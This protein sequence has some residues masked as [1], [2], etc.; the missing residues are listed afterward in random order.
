[1]CKSITSTNYQQH[2]S[3]NFYRC[4]IELTTSPAY[5]KV[6]IGTGTV[7]DS[8]GHVDAIINQQTNAPA[9]TTNE[10]E[11]IDIPES[12]VEAS[13]VYEIPNTTA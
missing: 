1:M 8:K 6:V 5:G 11:R 13:T 3:H 12:S 2:V 4:D 9:D 10:Y 7:D